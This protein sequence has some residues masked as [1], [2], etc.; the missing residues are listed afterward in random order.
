MSTKLST[1][2]LLPLLCFWTS[3]TVNAA[4]PGT[5]NVA[6]AAATKER[7]FVNTLGMKFVT[8]PGAKVLIC[9]HDTRKGDY[10]KYA[11]AN[12]DVDD[13]WKES[14]FKG[15]PVS[16]G[17]D[18]PVICVSWED[19]K[20]FCAWL[21]AKEGRSYR[22]PT[23]HEWSCAVGIGERED[24][25]ASP[26]SKSGKIEGIYPWGREWPPPQGAGNL[27]DSEF[28]KQAPKDAA[29]EGYSDGYVTTSPVMT[30]KPNEFGLYD[31]SGN[32][33]QY[34]EDNFIPQKPRPVMRGGSWN[35]AARGQLLSSYRRGYI[36]PDERV[37]FAIGFRC[38]LIP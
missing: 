11:D 3:L 36:G 27:A 29:I 21:S 12:R 28:H 32:V 33:W 26:A 15:A 24:P 7:P 9:I 23:D 17:E 8:V 31:M 2:L 13:S 34:C 20:A 25:S 38:V 35:I 19:A 5:E 18:H 14:F 37:H 16:A 10:R 4:D 30:Y 22:L 6:P 1:V